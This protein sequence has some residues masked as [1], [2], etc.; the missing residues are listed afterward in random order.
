MKLNKRS[1]AFGVALALAGVSGAQAAT[2]ING[3]FET[4]D[5]SGWTIG[6]GYRAGEYNSQLDPA[7]FLPGGSLY[8]NGVASSHSAVVAAG[9]VDPNVG[10]AFGT[11]VY[12]GN[13]SLRVEDTTY[14]GYASVATQT[15][16]N[17][18]DPSIFFA[19]KAVL[20]GAHGTNDAATLVIKLTDL[21]TGTDL[22]TRQYNAASG[23]SGVDP[24]FSLLNNN[25]Y[26][27]AWQIEQLN[28]DAGLAGHD[29]V[30]SVLAADCQPTGH[31]GYVYLDGFG[32]VAPPPT[33]VPEPTTLSLAGLGLLAMAG[34]AARRRR[35]K[36]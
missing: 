26:T 32:N 20:L 28:I 27:A 8:D 18:T 5:T 6:G 13:Y 7:D 12:G 35:Q 17:Y 16:N 19:W 14:G 24:R 9:T 21:T 36:A 31:W 11:T 34:A 22:I 4:G 10:A 3:D 29:F 2:F 15:V 25:Y 30:L 23:G 1:V 33:G